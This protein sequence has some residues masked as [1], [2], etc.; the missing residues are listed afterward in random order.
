[1]ARH[2]QHK[3]DQRAGEENEYR[4]VMPGQCP[5][6]VA[7]HLALIEQGA[8][9]AHEVH[10]L[11]NDVLEVSHD[12]RPAGRCDQEKGDGKDNHD[13]DAFQKIAPVPLLLR[14]Q[15][16]QVKK[17]HQ[18]QHPEADDPGVGR[19]TGCNTQQHR[20][21]DLPRFDKVN[22][23]RSHHQQQGGKHHILVVVKTIRKH[24]GTEPVHEHAH[25]AIFP[26]L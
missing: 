13:Q 11:G 24:P 6:A 15:H 5:E 1:M 9:P 4:H 2:H 17:A 26:V 25:N 19:K 8:F 3:K 23:Q 10:G 21:T 14:R 16:H 20:V 7:E 12:G 18:P 22:A